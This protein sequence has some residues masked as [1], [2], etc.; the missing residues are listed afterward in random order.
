LLNGDTDHFQADVRYCT[1]GGELAWA[2]LSVSI[3]RNADGAPLQYVAFVED[4]SK[5]RAQTEQLADLAARDP[6]TGLANRATMLDRIQAAVSA[7]RSDFALA[8]LDLDGFKA[9]NDRLGHQAGDEL[10]RVAAQ[11][12]R[13]SLRSTDVAG[14][15]GGD[16]FA[17]LLQPIE[18]ESHLSA[19]AERL[20]SAI[21]VPFTVAHAV[22]GLSASI[23]IA[24][25]NA[26]TAATDLLAEADAAM[27]MAKVAGRNTYRIS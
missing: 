24:R 5:R 6:L 1:P 26:V 16:E 7:D 23:G 12:I 3:I 15:Y 14:R 21:A 25:G 10:L 4:I 20:L 19:I 22:A 8:F 11:R 18:D 2:S 17:I 9:I 27:Y 13:D